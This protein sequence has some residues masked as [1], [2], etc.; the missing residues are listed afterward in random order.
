MVKFRVPR[1]GDVDGD[2]DGE[3]SEDD[4]VI[5]WC[6]CGV[7]D[8]ERV[9]GGGGGE[10]VWSMRVFVVGGFEFAFHGG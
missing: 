7:A 8:G 6:C 2:A 4:E 10:V 9:G 1:A 5:G 3:E